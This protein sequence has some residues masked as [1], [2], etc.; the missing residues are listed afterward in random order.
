MH[1][2]HI[3]RIGNLRHRRVI[4]QR[5]IRQLFVQAR[6][7]KMCVADHEQRVAIRR[8]FGRR[9]GAD[10]GARAGTVFN[11]YLLFEIFSKPLRQDAPRHI[12]RAAR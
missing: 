10:G 3:G 1:Q 11:H 9:L 12:R 4:I 5:V 7:D 2:Q 8:R 6:A